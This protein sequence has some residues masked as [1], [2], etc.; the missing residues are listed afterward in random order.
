[1]GDL[2]DLIDILD[3]DGVLHST[4]VNT[5]ITSRAVGVTSPV[6]SSSWFPFTGLFFLINSINGL[7][8]SIFANTLASFFGR[9]F[10]WDS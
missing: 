9:L 3:N 2:S 4:G 10:F 7:T 5:G 8:F 1:M 6:V